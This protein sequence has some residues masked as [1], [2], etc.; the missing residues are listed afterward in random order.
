VFG[1]SAFATTK[2][3][4]REDTPWFEGNINIV[5]VEQALCK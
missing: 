3:D 1:D 4:L 2:M 5:Q